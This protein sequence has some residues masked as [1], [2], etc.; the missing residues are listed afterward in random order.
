MVCI[1]PPNLEILPFLHTQLAI[2]LILG[3]LKLVSTNT[4]TLIGWGTPSHA[5]GARQRAERIR[6]P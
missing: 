5:F 2:E 6:I 1:L 4:R 3:V